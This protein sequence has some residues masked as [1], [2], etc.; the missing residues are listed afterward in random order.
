ML[1]TSPSALSSLEERGF[2]RVERDDR[3]LDVFP[4]E[5]RDRGVEL[6]EKWGEETV[7]IVR[8]RVL[9]D[10]PKLTRSFRIPRKRLEEA[11]LASEALSLNSFDLSAQ[12][13]IGAGQSR[14]PEP[15]P[16]NR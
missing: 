5:T 7:E 10:Q 8:L 11:L 4:K 3:L 2:G 15:P 16:E 12:S 6:W 13:A 1:N 14:Q 9:P